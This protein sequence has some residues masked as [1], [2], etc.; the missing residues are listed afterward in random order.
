M[1]STLSLLAAILLWAPV[2]RACNACSCM[3][4]NGLNAGLPYQQRQLVSLQYNWSQFE[5]MQPSAYAGRAPF[6]AT[7]LVQSFNASALI[8]LAPNWSLQPILP[9]QASAHLP[10]SMPLSAFEL[11]DISLL[12][13]HTILQNGTHT[14]RLAAGVQLPTGRSQ[15][16]NDADSLPQRLLTGTGASNILLQSQYFLQ[17]RHWRTQLNLQY[18]LA[19]I[20]KNGGKKGNTWHIATTIAYMWKQ[21]RITYIPF[22]QGI[23]Q[24]QQPDFVRY[25][26][27]LVDGSTGGQMMT[28]SFGA[29]FLWPRYGGS[30]AYNKNNAMATL[31]P[32][33]SSGIQ[34]NLFIT[35]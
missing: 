10:K 1:N 12:A 20:D 2:T 27:G 4:N 18:N 33:Q 14:T 13:Q 19:T 23:W 28:H 26:A 6:K 8:A 31:Y 16:W 35:F 3:A 11:G 17:K 5:Q 22:Y 29:Y 9:M 15:H 21:K 24:Y 34:T 7:Y 30:L 25:K 32:Q